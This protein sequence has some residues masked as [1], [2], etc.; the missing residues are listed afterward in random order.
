M[1]ELYFEG[2]RYEDG[3]TPTGRKNKRLR[4]IVKV[5]GQEYM[6]QLR[7]FV[8]LV[9]L[10]MRRITDSPEDGLIH[11]LEFEPR[12]DRLA[13]KYIYRLREQV[14]ALNIINDYA[15][16]YWLDFPPKA[17]KF[18]CEALAEFPNEE[19]REMFK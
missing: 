2:A 9:K 7:M 10:A 8:Y 4:C 11:I 18:N 3:T 5:N 13:Y 17:I 1:S 15:G 16:S 14:P 12:D 19:I 6:L